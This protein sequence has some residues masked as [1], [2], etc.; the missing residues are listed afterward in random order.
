[1]KHE[2]WIGEE[3]FRSADEVDPP[4]ARRGRDPQMQPRE[5]RMLDDDHAAD[6]VSEELF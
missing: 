2:L 5:Q 1:V 3:P 6:A 4:A